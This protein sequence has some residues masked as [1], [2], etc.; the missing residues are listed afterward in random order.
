MPHEAIRF[1][2]S[3]AA[4]C[5]AKLVAADKGGQIRRAVVNCLPESMPS[6]ML[7]THNAL[8]FLFTPADTLLASRMGNRLR[9]I[10]TDG[11]PHPA[12]PD[13]TF[14]ATRSSLGG[15]TLVVTL[16]GD[17]ERTSPPTSRG[18]P[19]N[20]ICTSSSVSTWST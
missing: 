14:T 13:P 20:G 10:Y 4:R 19:N 7:I 18:L 9:R 3:G 1:R 6:W 8:E 16:W 17:P 15:K 12:D 11:R 2:E 5:N